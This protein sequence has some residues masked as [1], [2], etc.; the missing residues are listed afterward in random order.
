[1]DEEPGAAQAIAVIRQECDQVL[2]SMATGFA[3]ALAAADWAIPGVRPQTSIYPD[4]VET[5]GGRVAYFLVDA[6]RFEMGVELAD[7]LEQARELSVDSTVAMLPTVTPIGMAALLPAASASFSVVEH[8]GKLAALVDATP[9]TNLSERMKFLKARVPD[10]VDLSLGDV[11][12]TSESKLRST[13][14]GAQLVLVRSQEIDAVGEL[15]TDLVRQVMETVIGNIARAV[16]KLASA[17]VESYVVAADHGHQFSRRKEEDMRTDNPG[18]DAVAL[19]RR[20]WVGRGGITPQ[21]TVRVSGAELGYETDLDFVFPTGLGVFKA[22]GG[23]SYHHGGISLQELVIPV[24]S[25][26][27][28]TAEAEPAVGSGIYL[29]DVPAAVTNRV[30]SVRLQVVGDVLST[31]PI[32]LR[33]VLVHAGEQVG[34]A[35]MAVD[36]DLDRDTGTATVKPGS[37]ASLG[38]MLTRE[39]CPSLRVV[40]QDPA[41]DAVLAQSDEIPVQ[42]GI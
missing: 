21:G 9:L 16:R 30:F 35:G 31:E 37:E 34:Q 40:V 23:L 2:T 26:R 36:A 20:C 1:M 18:G 25:F 4:L 3:T 38:L 10:V 15:D 12:Q 42:L 33:V 19:H 13:I 32:P 24:I 22:G 5:A 11:L 7:Q 39:D 27:M 41:T 17:G 8:G 28:P 14:D 29:G 6:M